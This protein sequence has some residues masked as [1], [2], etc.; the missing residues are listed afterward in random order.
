MGSGYAR[1]P[2]SMTAT[3][4]PTVLMRA[5]TDRGVLT[6]TGPKA[7]AQHEIE[8]VIESSQKAPPQSR[9][10]GPG[11]GG[12]RFDPAIGVTISALADGPQG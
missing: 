4:S 11:S 3:R 10:S 6:K 9:V 7:A 8:Q 12:V 2:A 5:I 1:G